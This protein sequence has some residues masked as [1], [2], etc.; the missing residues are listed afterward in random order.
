MSEKR[1]YNRKLITLNCDFCGNKFQKP[2]TEYKRCQRLGRHSY[3]SR[4]CSAKGDVLTKKS[5][6]HK[7]ASDKMIEHLKC[8]WNNKRDEY[9]PFRYSLR[10]ARTR[11]QEVNITL[12]DLKEL[13]EKQRGICPDTGFR[14]IL[15]EN[16]NVSHID[17]FHRASLDRID[18]TKGY[19][20]GNIQFI[21]TPINL[22]KQSQS[23]EAVKRFLK[24]ISTYTAMLKV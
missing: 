17:F 19:V 12:D 11:F 6:P 9:T 23:D 2:L 24:E 3:C 20:K 4:E 13:W 14:L 1:K 16:S 7:P 21:S 18:S 22:M 10:C 8:I 5:N 15:P